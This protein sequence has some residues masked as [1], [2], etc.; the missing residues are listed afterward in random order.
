M[1]NGDPHQ[2][3]GARPFILIPGE[4]NC[5]PSLT[6]AQIGSL[7]DRLIASLEEIV[8]RISA[9]HAVNRGSGHPDGGAVDDVLEGLVAGHRADLDA[10]ATALTA[11]ADGT[12]GVCTECRA[13]IPFDQLDRRPTTRRCIAHLRTRPTRAPD[14]PDATSTAKGRPS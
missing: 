13:P 12:Y 9:A 3:S 5:E 7:H 8:G 14:A 1:A 10:A 11:I 2:T 6:E 4:A